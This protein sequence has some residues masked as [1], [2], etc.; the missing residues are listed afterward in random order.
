MQHIHLVVHIYTS[1]DGIYHVY[2]T[3]TIIDLLGDFVTLY[4]YKMS[5]RPPDALYPYGYGI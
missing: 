2:N 5:K 1:D 3:K 4:T